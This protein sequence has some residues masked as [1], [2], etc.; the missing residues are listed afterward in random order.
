MRGPIRFVPWLFI[1]LSLCLQSVL[2]AGQERAVFSDTGLRI[3]TK[4][5]DAVPDNAQIYS[6]R[7]QSACADEPQKVCI[8][9]KLVLRPGVEVD[10]VLPSILTGL[11]VFS[12][13]PELKIKFVYAGVSSSMGIPYEVVPDSDPVEVATD[14]HGN[15]IVGGDFLISFSPG[16]DVQFAEGVVSSLV[17]YLIPQPMDSVAKT[18]WGGIFLNP[19]YNPNEDYQLARVIASEVGRLLGVSGSAMKQSLF[20]PFLPPAATVVELSE[21]DLMW[22]Q[23]LYASDVPHSGT[24]SLSGRIKSG[25]DGQPIAG[26]AVFLIPA[27]TL[28]VFAQTADWQLARFQAF[29][30]EE[31]R[32]E[33]PRL[34]AGDYFLAAGT[35]TDFGLDPGHFDDWMAAFAGGGSIGIEFYDGAERE[36]NLENS[37]SFSPALIRAAAT[38][39]VVAAEETS[40]VELISNVVNK[41]VEP[42]KASGST[43]ESPSQYQFDLEERLRGLRTQES[44][45]ERVETARSGC[46]LYSAKQKNSLSLTLELA[47]LVLV[48]LFGVGRRRELFHSE[49]P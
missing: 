18:Q 31:G 19:A 16:D 1:I 35:L 23:S 41:D 12:Q 37:M 48:A 47:A 40:G 49:C 38:I 14:E 24:G 33:F 3:W 15:Q 10:A 28:E 44:Q 26:A 4:H 30:D 8:T 6:P 27:Q 34:T 42:I 45:L 39:H 43:N 17:K 21:D 13:K 9:W 29:S 20:Y 7:I 2:G 32:F 25:A 46:V 5:G 22:T 11:S 36:S